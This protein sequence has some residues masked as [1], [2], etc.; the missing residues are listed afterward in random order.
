MTLD[1]WLPC[2]GIKEVYF[3]VDE[4]LEWLQSSL[5]PYLG[6]SGRPMVIKLDNVSIHVKDS[7][8]KAI[9]AAG[10]VI[11]F[12]P[13]YSPDYNSIELTFSVLK[14]WMKKY[15]PFLRQAC[16]N[17]GEFLQLAITE[18]RCDRFAAS[19]SS[20]PVEKGSI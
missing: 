14:A 6:T 3:N 16:K 15:W 2:T 9:E 18:G 13:P 19:N 17:Y 20:T 10:H 7:V 5:L 8:V 4:F 12:L 1:S 11:N